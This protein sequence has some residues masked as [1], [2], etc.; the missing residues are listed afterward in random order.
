MPVAVG[1]SSEGADGAL[2]AGV[3]AEPAPTGA[4]ESRP[5]PKPDVLIVEDDE[6]EVRFI[7]RALERQ[8]VT[9]RFKIVRSGEAALEYLESTS[10]QDP[11]SPPAPKVV[12]LDLKLSGIDGTEVLR[13]IRAHDGL[14]TIPVVI[15][16]STSSAEEICS[17]YR[18]G[19]NSFVAK[20][21]RSEN[22][23]AHV[24]EISRYWL[25]LNRPATAS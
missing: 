21:A 3:A 20:P 7:A 15:L 2:A 5:D 23:G 25:D 19:A 17:C 6:D 8:G 24:L 11:R 22:P 1:R 16:S 13:R 9:G 12:L 4:R 18:L 14:C 10:R